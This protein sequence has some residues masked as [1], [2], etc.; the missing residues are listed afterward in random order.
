MKPQIIKS[1]TKE[2]HS[3]NDD[4]N[5]EIKIDEEK[6]LKNLYI[7]EK[8]NSKCNSSYEDKSKK[9]TNYFNRNRI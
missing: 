8:E 4:I 3:I 2:S 1:D 5:E 6:I 7:T 9:L